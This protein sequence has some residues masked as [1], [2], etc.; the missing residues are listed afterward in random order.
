MKLVFGHNLEPILC[1]VVGTDARIQLV[2]N[3]VYVVCAEVPPRPSKKT[4]AAKTKL[5]TKPVFMK[6]Y[7]T[8]RHA[9]K[10]MPRR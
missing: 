2:S 3:S 6:S 9:L 5:V 7:G 8:V 1:V 10:R 4:R